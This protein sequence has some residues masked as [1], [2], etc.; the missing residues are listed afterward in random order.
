MEEL[1]ISYMEE[2][3]HK[4]ENYKHGKDIIYIEGEKYTHKRKVTWKKNLNAE[5]GY[6]REERVYIYIERR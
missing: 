2:N 4:R 5:G 1:Y 6:V 3:T